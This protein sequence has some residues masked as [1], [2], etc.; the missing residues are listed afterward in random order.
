MM[1]LNVSTDASDNKSEM[2][3]YRELGLLLPV[4]SKPAEAAF[5]LHSVA[6]ILVRV[7]LSIRMD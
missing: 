5:V 4:Y 6:F 3:S 7:Q 2:H 1:S